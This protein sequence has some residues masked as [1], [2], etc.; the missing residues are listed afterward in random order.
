MP[1]GPG[2][3]V[4]PALALLLVASACAQTSPPTAMVPEAGGA[5]LWSGSFQAPGHAEAAMEV[6]ARAPGTGWAQ[7]GAQ[8]AVLRVTL[9]GEYVGDVVAFLGGE[10]HRYPF[11]LGPVEAGEHRATLQPAPGKGVAAPLEVTGVTFTLYT[12]QHPLYPVISH[13]PLLYGRAVM[14]RSDTPLLAYHERADEAGQTVITY[15]VIF[16]NEDA[17]TQP[18]ALMARWGRLTD[19][20]WVYRVTLDAAGTPV[21]EAIQGKDHQV[22]PFA[23][24]RRGRHPILRVATENNMVADSGTADLLFAPVF[25]ASLGP[26]APREA[27]MDLH[28]WTYRVMAEEWSREGMEVPGQPGTPAVSD[29][30]NYLYVT[31]A[32]RFEPAA[33]GA[34]CDLRLA[35]AVQERTTGTWYSSDHGN[36]DLRVSLAG[37]RRLAI[38]LPPGVAPEHLGQLRLQVY[39][40]SPCRLVI[41]R[42]GPVFLLDDAYRPGPSLFTW[43]GAQALDGSDST[44]EP[45]VLVL[46]R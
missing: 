21:Q 38:E 12:P 39:G 1:A 24:R 31:Y 15:T 20:E 23:G 22:L 7:Q 43:Q 45:A 4:A 41:E 6:T 18:P 29:P 10:L 13:S 2:F 26:G 28:P 17:G 25:A 5:A 35:A 9:D 34:R 8:A 33:A 46:S 27:M 44:P 11:L 3:R 14:D 37:W 36:G 30:R 19:I 32:A 16:S 40:A 42:V